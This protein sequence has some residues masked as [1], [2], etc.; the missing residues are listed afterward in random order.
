MRARYAAFACG[1]ASFIMGTT[2]PAGPAFERGAAAWERSLLAFCEQTAF[3]GLEI[4]QVSEAGDEG[5]VEFR[6]S[7]QQPER[8][9]SFTELSRFVRRGG[10][11]LYHSGRVS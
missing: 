4:Q 11:W 2:D 8:D 6:A 10:R 5:A 3:E 9:V 1:L 7:L